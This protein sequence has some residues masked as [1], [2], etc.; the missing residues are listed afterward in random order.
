MPFASMTGFARS[1]G[2]SGSTRWHWEARSVNGRGLDLRLRLP[3]G[4]EALE[5]RVR[6][7]VGRRF[8]RGNIS[9]SL[10]TTRDEA[11]VD[12]R[13]NEAVLE[14]VLAALVRVQANTALGFDRPRPEA[15]LAL[16]GVLEV[17]EAAES[18]AAVEARAAAMLA[19]LETALADLARARVEEGGRLARVL[20][21]QL[22]GI[23]RLVAKIAASPSRTPEAVRARLREQ[24]Q[25]L[26]DASATLDEGRL[27]QEA[28]MIATRADIEE[29]LK[30]LVAHVAAAR[31]LIAAQEP[32][33]RRF[34]F[35][36]QE[37]N[38]EANTLCSKSND[39]EITRAGLELKAVIDQ[40]REQVQNIE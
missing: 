14:R 24:L 8:T 37:F 40:M 23:E 25:R 18:E 22:T 32:V 21:D 13:L 12:L 3:P 10:T 7:A 9:L 35:L 38:R 33:G 27:Y 5:P 11:T 31:D 4:S 20:A 15:V 2:T 17:E 29:E 36:T 6:E 26:L 39:I 34:E 19:S 16:R 30:R 1:D 28:A